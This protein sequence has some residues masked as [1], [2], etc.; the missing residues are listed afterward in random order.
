[1][2]KAIRHV[3]QIIGMPV[4]TVAS[5]L[6]SGSKGW[7]LRSRMV[8]Q[9]VRPLRIARR[10][11]RK[12]HDAILKR[13]CPSLRCHEASYCVKGKGALEAA[14]LHARH[15]YLLHLDLKDFFPSVTTRQ[16]AT[17]LSSSG[18]PDL[19]A[20]IIADLV[21]CDDQLPQGASTSVA[22]G[23][24]VLYELDIRI[25]GI[26]RKHGLSYTQYVDDLAISGGGRIARHKSLIERVI[27]DEGWVIGGKGGLKGKYEQHRY[28]G[29]IL[30]AT[31]NVDRSYVKDL[32][33]LISRNRIKPFSERLLQQ[34][35]GKLTYVTA[36][37]PSLGRSL[38]SQF[39][40]PLR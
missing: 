33:F 35:R 15:P 19:E 37:N 3:A 5:V 32:R 30:N 29:V 6:A 18:L 34:V 26:C 17:A 23:N 24:T 28:L 7:I 40:K 13:L 9:K 10:E 16:V 4:A 25:A 36:L 1:V 39:E 22:I 20:R 38:A 12:V 31:P 27:A 14:Q 11:L 21:T 8:R 2:K